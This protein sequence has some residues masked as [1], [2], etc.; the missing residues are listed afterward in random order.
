MMNHD[1]IVAAV[2]MGSGPDWVANQ[3]K[4]SRLV[5]EAAARG[6]QL[7]VLPELWRCY[8]PLAKAANQAEPMPGPITDSFAELAARLGI[9]LCAGSFAE[10]SPQ[11]GKAWN[12]A[13]VFDAAGC[14]I[15]RYRKRHLFDADLPPIGSSTS[16][17]GSSPQRLRESDSM[18]AGDDV[19]TFSALGITFGL[20]ICYD[21][22]FPEL[23]RE[24]SA[25]GAEA[26]LLPAAF[27]YATG[28]DHWQVLLRAR[29]IENQ[30]YVVAAN[31]GG[32]HPGGLRSY[33]H[34]AIIDP[35]G[36]IVA[37]LA[38]EEEGIVLATLSAARVGEVR[39]RLPAL[40][41]RRD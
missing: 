16:A 27:T 2:Q 1:R 20:A 37:E 29:A 39:M 11:T 25:A 33:G 35:W 7:V 21:L 17:T 28:R 6:A 8:G 41:H 10:Q 30:C 12:S 9:V 22:R 19:C 18:L 26:I 38:S 5:E 31:Q 4:A 36:E 15:A 23:F 34:S 13:I 3:A 14:E 32:E 24:H 40:K